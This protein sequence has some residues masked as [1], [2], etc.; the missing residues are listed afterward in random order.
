M[1]DAAGTPPRVVRS[2]QPAQCPAC[3]GGLVARIFRGM[4]AYDQKLLDDLDAGRIVLGGC[5]MTNDDPSWQCT[6]CGQKIYR[7]ASR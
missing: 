4:P 3:G 2:S 7:H 1:K 5:V 6:Q